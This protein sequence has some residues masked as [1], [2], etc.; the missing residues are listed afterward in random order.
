[1]GVGIIAVALRGVGVGV[2]VGVW[3]G[4]ARARGGRR[5]VAGYQRRRRARLVYLACALG[6]DL[7]GFH[8][9][10]RLGGGAELT[11]YF[12]WLAGR[13]VRLVEQRAGE[14][15]WVVVIVTGLTCFAGFTATMARIALGINCVGDEV[16]LAV[17]DIVSQRL[18]YL[19]W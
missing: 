4:R 12:P 1:M 14:V 18:I 7:V 5:V 9:V 2:G 16:G 15:C 19:S 3:S 17:R 6:G 13:G 10:R 11:G 8:L